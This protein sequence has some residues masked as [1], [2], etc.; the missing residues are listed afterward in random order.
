MELKYLEYFDLSGNC[1]EVL[2]A[3]V[4]WL[5]KP[6]EASSNDHF[7]LHVNK[8]SSLTELHLTNS[9]LQGSLTLSFTN[10]T[11]LSFLDLSGNLFEALVL[12]PF[13]K[14]DSLVTLNLNLNK[15]KG[16]IPDALANLTSLQQLDLSANG[17]GDQSQHFVGFQ[18]LTVESALKNLIA[19]KSSRRLPRSLVFNHDHGCASDPIFGKHFFNNISGLTSLN[20]LNLSYNELVGRIPSGNQLQM[21]EDPSIYEGNSKLCGLPLSL[22]CQDNE[23]HDQAPN[24]VNG[25]IEEDEEGFELKWFYV[26][27]AVGFVVGYFGLL[28]TLWVKKGWRNACSMYLEGIIDR[29]QLLWRN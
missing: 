20:H 21:L 25:D 6:V 29:V 26:S 10:L 19:F 28:G 13:V 18:K 16:S 27:M 22:K 11:H 12:N 23:T 14:L 1:F 15:F 4:L 17:L 8:L 9:L 2:N 5:T 7:L 3:H 24:H